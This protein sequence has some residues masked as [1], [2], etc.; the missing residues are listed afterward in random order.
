MASIKK[1]TNYL[2][3]GRKIS[4]EIIDD[5]EYYILLDGNRW[6]Y[7]NVNEFIPFKKDTLE[8]SCI[9]HIEDIVSAAAAAEKEKAIDVDAKVVE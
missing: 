1:D 9:A 2:F 5:K 6:I 3:N 7:Q 4:Y 8:A